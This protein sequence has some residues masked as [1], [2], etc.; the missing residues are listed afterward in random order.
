LAERVAFEY[1][2]GDPEA[3]PGYDIGFRV[4]GEKV[5]NYKVRIEYI[6]EGKML[7]NILSG[8]KDPFKNV[9][10]IILDEAHE[11]SVTCDLLIGCFKSD[12]P[13]W[14]HIIIVVTSATIDL[15]HFSQ[16]YNDAPT[17]TV[18]GRTFPVRLNYNPVPGFG[19]DN[20]TAFVNYSVSSTLEIHKAQGR[21]PGDI[22]C[23][24][25]GQAD[26]LAAKEM[27]EAQFE[28]LPAV[29]KELL[30]QPRVLPLYGR[31]E[32]SEQTKIFEH[33]PQHIRKI[34]FAT[35]IAETSVTIDGVVHVVDAG[36]KKGIVYDPK[37]KISSLRLQ[38]ISKSSA[39]QRAGRAGRT[40]P[41]ECYRLYAPDD[42]ETM[43]FGSA[44]E[45]LRKPLS[46]AVLT[47]RKLKLD[48]REFSWIS[49][50]PVDSMMAAEEELFLLGALTL[51]NGEP[52]LTE[53][54]HLISQVQ[55]E[56]SLVKMIYHGCRN[57]FGEAAVTLASIFTVSNIFFWNGADPKSKAEAIEKRKQFSLVDGDI[58][59][60]FRAFEEWVEASISGT[61]L[62]NGG[63]WCVA[64]SVN[65]KA[66][67]IIM[68]T[69]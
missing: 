57:G 1:S 69:R 36:V 54:G 61:S 60:L 44:P 5:T 47:L 33:F 17:V 2:C 24:L 66:M 42:F 52:K 25:P 23:F 58:V 38:Q 30:L 20:S 37:R 67:K 12:D 45:V 43:E 8:T 40:Q 19:S 10:C 53:L 6:T 50:P 55:Q 41:G 11:R 21:V 46:L 63:A 29:E 27:F 68:S 39:I 32:P 3:V 22:L 4:A 65:G 15:D 13:R 62:K 28:R 56:P 9:G 59:S 18:E 49:K 7:E 35:D 26:V 31:M 34:I 14:K 48:P 64:N 51:E 16:F